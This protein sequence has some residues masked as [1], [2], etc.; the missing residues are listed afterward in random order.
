[1]LDA[2]D[3]H[4]LEG[5]RARPILIIAR[6]SPPPSLHADAADPPEA[7]RTDDKH[8]AREG[9]RWPATILLDPR[10]EAFGAYRIL[11]QPTIVVIDAKATVV[12]SYSGPAWGEGS[13]ES[14]VELLV[15]MARGVDPERIA[16]LVAGE[17]E[18]AAAPPEAARAERLVHLASELARHGLYD[19][20]EARYAE[21]TAAS[22]G[23]QGAMLGLAELQ[24]KRGR[25]AEA[26]ALFRSILTR[27]PDAAEAELGLIAVAVMRSDEA[28]ADEASAALAQA[29]ADT[30]GLIA[31]R[32][33]LPRAHYL[34]GLVLEKRGR[35]AEAASEYRKA[36]EML[37]DR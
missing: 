34:L 26:E 3:D 11:V 10:R 24:L 5:H 31:R 8:E 32:P 18:P 6:D 21:A 12:R 2:L 16:R 33:D 30:A 14:L 23:H 9:R 4:R 13:K 20:A 15:L 35:R 36:A 1:M 19:L 17:G 22:P 7:A 25:G 27:S 37:L 29:E 28:P